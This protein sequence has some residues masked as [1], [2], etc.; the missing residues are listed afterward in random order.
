[1]LSFRKWWF[2]IFPL[3][4]CLVLVLG[5]FNLL[6]LALDAGLLALSLSGG[7]GRDL[8]VYLVPIWGFA[9]GY[10][11]HAVFLAPD[12]QIH[13]AD[14]YA[15]ELALFGIGGGGAVI[16]PNE[17]FREHHWL[18]ADVVC[19]VT[20]IVY[21]LPPIF[22]AAWLYIKDRAA[23]SAVCWAVFLAHVVGFTV[24]VLFPAAPPWYVAAHGLGPADLAAPASAAGAARFDDIV[25]IPIFA[26]FYAQNRNV[27]AAVPSMHVGLQ[28]VIALALRPKHPR[29]AVAMWAFSGL[30][31]FSAVYLD[32][33]YV[34]DLLAGVLAAAAGYA[35]SWPVV[36]AVQ[37]TARERRKGA[38]GRCGAWT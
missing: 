26:N 11:L 38:V 2:A 37:V 14:V 15:A 31:A 7:R 8:A 16:T 20:Y 6:H 12:R 13:V 17:Y 32:H 34:V 33:H 21:L 3:H 28:V 19:G 24:Y 36:G 30:V 1:M 4:L 29:L 27:F 10:D 9:A 22:L 35:L 23:G 18:L 25:G 5:R